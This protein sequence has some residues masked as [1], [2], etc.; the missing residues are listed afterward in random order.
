MYKEIPIIGLIS[1][2]ITIVLFQSCNTKPTETPVLETKISGKIVDK[3]NNNGLTGAQVTTNPTTS[4][5]LTDASG[6]YTISDVKPGQYVVSASKAGYSSNT[7]NVVVTEGKTSSADIQLEVL[8][9]GLQVSTSFV[10][11]GSTQTTATIILSNGTS[12]GSIN[13]SVSKSVDW[14]SISS[15]SGTLT[16]GTATLTIT[17]SRTNL[18]FGNYNT[19][20]SITS[21]AGN[22]DI[23]INMTVPNPNAP[24]LTVAPLLLDFDSNISTLVFTVR[25]SGTGK[26][27]WAASS[28]QS[29]ISMIPNGDSTR[30]EVD[31]VTV[32]VNRNG[33]SSG[34]YTGDI[35]VTSNAGSQTVNVKLS[36]PT[37]PSLSLSTSFLDFDSTKTQLSFTV[38]NS[39]S[40]TLNWSATGNQSWMSVAP[41]S[42]TN[43]GTV[44]VTISKSGLSAGTY[45]GTVTINSNGGTGTISVNAK[46]LP[47]QPPS[48]V[49]VTA[50][51][52]TTN[53]IHINWT[54]SQDVN[55]SAYKIY[56]S[57][58][59][60][61]SENSTLASTILDKATTGYTIT[62]LNS[63]TTYY[64][65]VFVLNSQGQS[66]GSNTVTATTEKTIPT[67]QQVALPVNFQVQSMHYISESNI[68][69]A[70]YTTISGYNFPRIYQFNGSSW[71]QSNVQTQDSVGGISALAF[72]NNSEGFAFS[73]TYRKIYKFD[74]FKWDVIAYLNPS[75]SYEF[76]EAVGTTSDVWIYGSKNDKPLIMR[77]D[78]SSFS[79]FIPSQDG[80]DIVDMHFPAT[81][82]GFAGDSYYSR[83]KCYLFNGI[84]WIELPRLPGEYAE[85]KSISGVSDKDIWASDRVFLYH[86]DGSA[87]VRQNDIGGSGISYKFGQIRM[88]S[89]NQGWGVVDDTFLG[90]DVYYYNGNTW[91]KTGKVS[92]SIKEIK[93]FGNENL[94]GII[95][96]TS[97][98]N[99]LMRLK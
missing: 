24:Q 65:R 29:W 7:I 37:V 90:G 44:N 84:G 1:F 46:V 88:I 81:N 66:T 21:N 25:N 68:W 78:G 48:P 75:S 69:V 34:D 26:I 74:G 42:G 70:G 45:S 9:P 33:L 73:G 41:S 5:V 3:D 47:P 27:D 2:V 82:L 36:V 18:S 60:S 99:K 67:W 19:V 50:G 13:W 77:W 94:W 87:W 96:G 63:N 14:I 61:V 30:T 31:Q 32:S 6:S 72:K 15:A 76:L 22:K 40:G 64:A 55:F 86:F 4:S 39:G 91:T 16:T 43:T 10:D 51:S 56:Y 57:T 58:S 8:K 62:G 93:D 59:A 49:N 95:Y 97:S 20:L 17:A 12:V 38:N 85:V 35:I 89:K 79:E 71:S 98:P 28:S 80:N 52:P 92:G 23:Q 11:F 53:S 83:G 54:A